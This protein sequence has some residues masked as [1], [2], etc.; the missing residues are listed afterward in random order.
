MAGGHPGH[1]DHDYGSTED[2]RTVAR[3]QAPS[4]A[5]AHFWEGHQV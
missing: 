2:A 5:M 4:R 1:S 3:H